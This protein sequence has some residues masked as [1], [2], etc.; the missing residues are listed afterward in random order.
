M[1]KKVLVTGLI[2]DGD[3]LLQGLE[4]QSFPISAALWYYLPEAERWRLVIASQFVDS[5]GPMAAY[6]LV[7]R[8]LATLERPTL[9]L[10]DVSVVSPHGA[11]FQDLCLDEI[12]LRD[13]PD[14]QA[15]LDEATADKEKA[16]ARLVEITGK[17]FKF[18]ERYDYRSME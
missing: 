2:R 4:Q 9:L 1:L 17:V 16:E 8:V 12:V 6:M 13:T 14:V 7:Q 5:Q 11:D 15:Q 10:S 3:L 18:L